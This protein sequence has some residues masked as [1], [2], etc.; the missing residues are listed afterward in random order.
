[1]IS[2]FGRSKLG[3]FWSWILVLGLAAAGLPVRNSPAAEGPVRV[4]LATVIPRGTSP[5]IALLEMR[6]KW[7][8]ASA[9]GV[10]L[11][12]YPDG[13]MGGEAE[14]VRRMR[15]G[16]IQAAMLSVE[17]LSEIDKSVTALQ[18]MP[19]MFRSLD[20]LTYVREKLRPDL[21]KR[22]LDKGFVVLFWGDIGWVR[23][24]SKDA[25]VHPAEFKK[26]KLFVWAG[27]N[28]Q[29]ELMKALGFNPVPLETSD[30]LTGL[31]TGLINAVATAPLYAL[32]GQFYGPCSHMLEINYAPLGGATV[33]TRK[34]WDSIPPAT[35]E[36][37]L[38]AAAEAGEQVTAKGRAESDAALE[39]MKK[40]GLKVQTVTPAIEAEW[41]Q[42][43]EGVYPKIRGRMVPAEMFDQ[44]QNLLRDYRTAGGGAK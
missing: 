3:T 4:K 21:E 2:L 24:F 11:A 33:I 19:F 12:I 13:L 41:R 30:I 9:G 43:L 42:F 35:R 37:L 39:A 27:D 34:T 40:R 31:Q 10:D 14:T 16:Q 22:L 5:H 7:R 23:F 15:V 25:A 29:V 32:A 44:V 36:A 8:Q 26:F 6:A 20:E 1:M 18:N 38:K 17:G 28:D